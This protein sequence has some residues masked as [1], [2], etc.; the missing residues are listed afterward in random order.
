[1][2]VKVLGTS[3]TWFVRNNTSFVIDE[4][5]VFDLPSGNYKLLAAYTKTMATKCAIITHFHSDHFGDFRILTT[6]I[7][8][9]FDK[10][11]R[12]E[13]LRV[14]A[15]K[16]IVQKIIET[17]NLFCAG[18]DECNE[19][20]LREHIDFIE[21]SDGFEFEEGGYKIKAFKMEHG[22]PETYGFSFTDSDGKVVAFSADTCMCENLDKLLEKADFAFVEMSAK[23]E[24]K[25]HLSIENFLSLSKKYNKTKIYPIH[26]SDACQKYAIENGLNVV[27]DGDEFVF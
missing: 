25:T 19:E 10:Y 26:T 14:Y 15:P 22:R 11:G 13:N 18:I 1:M 16:G 12:T 3:C 17:N 20:L 8:R 9:H 23:T 2:K 4:N 5:I 27:N 21:L 24:H 7:M 6:E